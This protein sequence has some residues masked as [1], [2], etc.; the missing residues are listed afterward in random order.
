VT[1][2][3]GWRGP[4][5][6]VAKPP[7]TIRI[8][9]VG[10]SAVVNSHH[11]PYSYPE[12]VGHW[13]NLWAARRGLNAH[14]EVLNAGREGLY[15]TDIAAVVRKEVVPVAPDLVVYYEGGNQFTLRG[16]LASDV[17]P[18]PMQTAPAPQKPSA[19]WLS[20]AAHRS[21]LARR[22]YNAVELA[23]RSSRTGEELPK[24]AYDL[25]WPDGLSE[26]APDLERSD[27]P[28]NLSTIV[29]DLE[30]MRKDLQAEGAELAIST[31]KWFVRDGLVVDPV[32]NHALWEH[33]NIWMWPFRYRDLERLSTFQNRVY[34]RYAAAH[35][36]PLIDVAGRMPDEPEL[37]TD[38]VHFSYGGVRLHAWIV[39]QQLVPLIEQ[40]LS[41][42]LWPQ[43][44]R[45][46]VPPPGLLFE[47]EVVRTEC[48]I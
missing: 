2:E 21:A 40:R 32:R 25:R 38:A 15:S 39:L 37:Y 29:S 47:P 34:A 10:A 17:G 6:T 9:F 3:I 16:M 46:A 28:A 43:E 44:R 33:L 20:D 7:N 31:F 26:I 5:M 13:L 19:Q 42:G 45:P 18:A 22:F 14:I 24:P 4:P 11:Y 30:R 1:N 48:K 27:L 41:S 23:T 12:F 35:R 36:L 8:V